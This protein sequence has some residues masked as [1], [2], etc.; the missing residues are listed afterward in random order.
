MINWFIL[1]ENIFMVTKI[2]QNH[3]SK[4]FLGLMVLLTIGIYSCNDT[5][6]KEEKKD[7]AAGMSKDTSMK[8][9]TDSTKMDS[10]KKDTTGRGGQ[11][12]PPG[13]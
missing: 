10:T 12:P 3:F 6:S 5:A 1:H 11:T 8:M 4:L 9:G 2:K 7:T 13:H